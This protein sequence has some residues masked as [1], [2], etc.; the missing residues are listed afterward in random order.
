M[1][2][3][4]YRLTEIQ[5]PQSERAGLNKQDIEVTQIRETRSG[6]KIEK[7]IVSRRQ[8]RR[9]NDEKLIKID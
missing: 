5:E 1:D 9:L 6:S 3:W 7:K 2:S 4:N 8:V